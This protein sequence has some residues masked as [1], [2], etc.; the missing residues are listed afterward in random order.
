MQGTFRDKY[1]SIS[2]FEVGPGLEEYNFA[3]RLSFVVVDNGDEGLGPSR[4]GV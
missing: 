3:R 1:C 2:S 4:R